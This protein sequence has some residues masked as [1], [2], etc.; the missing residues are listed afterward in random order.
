MIG[1][2]ALFGLLSLL[3]KMMDAMGRGVK[4]KEQ[5]NARVKKVSGACEFARHKG[6]VTGHR[7]G[8]QPNLTPSAKRHSRGGMP[9]RT[10]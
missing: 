6:I 3:K 4:K 5:K 7:V 9:M 2:M 8:K 10:R 1:G